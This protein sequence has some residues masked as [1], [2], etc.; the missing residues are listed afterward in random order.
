M[1][2]SQTYAYGHI[3]KSTIGFYFSKIINRDELQIFCNIEMYSMVGFFLQFSNLIIVIV[4]SNV[5]QLLLLTEPL[6]EFRHLTEPYFFP[7]IIVKRRH[8]T[9]NY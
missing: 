4:Y 5:S 6:Q 7:I 8:L 1:V 3:L 9:N 2:L